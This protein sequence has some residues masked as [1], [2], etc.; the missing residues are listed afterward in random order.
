MGGNRPG[1]RGLGGRDVSCRDLKR[2]FESDNA[3]SW[4]SGRGTGTLHPGCQMGKSPLN[5][6]AAA[7]SGPGRKSDGCS[8]AY[9]I[10]RLCL[11]D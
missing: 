6:V 10:D 1:L 4:A 9:P 3:V 8:R 11:P 7:R 5:Q 2:Q